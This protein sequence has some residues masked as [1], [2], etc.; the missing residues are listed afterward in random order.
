M[1]WL[2]TYLLKARGYELVKMGIF[3]GLPFLSLGLA[4]PLGGWFSD[5]VLKRD[6]A[7]SRS[8]WPV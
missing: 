6:A 3:A 7:K 2:P 4:Q 8:S 5:H 1:T